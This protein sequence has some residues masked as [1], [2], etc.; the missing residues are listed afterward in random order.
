MSPG[1]AMA[2]TCPHCGGAGT[3]V[4]EHIDPHTGKPIK[5]VKPCGGCGGKG[6]R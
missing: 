1:R 3:V 6:E 2:D 4:E 5:V